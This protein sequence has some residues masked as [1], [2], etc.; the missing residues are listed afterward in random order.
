MGYRIDLPAQAIGAD[1]VMQAEGTFVAQNGADIVAPSAFQITRQNT[2]VEQNVSAAFANYTYAK[3][4]TGYAYA[5]F[6]PIEGSYNTPFYV[7]F[8]RV[9]GS[10][11]NYRA[12]YTMT[13]GG[14]ATC[15]SNAI[16]S[17]AY[18]Q[19]PLGAYAVGYQIELP[20]TTTGAD[21]VMNA[22]VAFGSS[23]AGGSDLD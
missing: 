9:S 17:T 18:I 19:V 2:Q 8:E 11:G 21:W 1:W 10:Y 6:V 15:G 16:F 13:A 20:A 12:C 4:D 3:T 14:P 22:T 5:T 7:N 23:S